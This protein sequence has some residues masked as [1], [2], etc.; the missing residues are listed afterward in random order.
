MPKPTCTTTIVLLGALLSTASGI[1]VKDEETLE[2]HAGHNK[3]LGRLPDSV[4]EEVLEPKTLPEFWDRMQGDNNEII[5]SYRTAGKIRSSIS[6]ASQYPPWWFSPY[7]PWRY[8][9][10]FIAKKCW[11]RENV[12]DTEGVQV[13]DRLCMEECSQQQKARAKGWKTKKYVD[14]DNQRGNLY[15]VMVYKSLKKPIPAGTVSLS[16]KACLRKCILKFYKTINWKHEARHASAL[17]ET[18]EE[19]TAETAE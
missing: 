9:R 10:A 2:V 8:T 12:K 5:F 4:V 1:K 18:A 3:S 11:G 7:D 19:E 15:K 6:T 16:D 13:M 17:E 14:I